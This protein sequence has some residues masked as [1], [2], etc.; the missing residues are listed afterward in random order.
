VFHKRKHNP[1]SRGAKPSLKSE[2]TVFY[3]RKHNPKVR[4]KPLLKSE[5]K[6]FHQKQREPQKKG[7][8][9]SLKDKAMMK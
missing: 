3:K 8:K 1:E 5:A 4:G 7:A 9:P 6:V 2:D